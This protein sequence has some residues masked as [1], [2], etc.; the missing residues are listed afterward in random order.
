MREGQGRTLAMK[1]S[2]TAPNIC[3]Y[4]PL[5]LAISHGRISASA[6]RALMAASVAA[7]PELP[8]H[9]GPWPWPWPWLSLPFPFPLAL[10]LEADAV[11]RE[12]ASLHPSTT[13][14]TRASAALSRKA[15]ADLHLMLS[16]PSC[17]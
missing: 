2:L 12:A 16:T 15:L 1:S 4:L 5:A 13:V 6:P 9:A 8:P 7:V 14:L 3:S 10:S 17:S 11:D